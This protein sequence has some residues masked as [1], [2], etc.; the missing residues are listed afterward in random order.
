MIDHIT[1]I[2]HATHPHLIYVIGYIVYVSIDGPSNNKS[3]SNSILVIDGW[4]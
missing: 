4:D 2:F 3:H 1:C